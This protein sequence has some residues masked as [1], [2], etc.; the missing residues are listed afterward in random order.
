MRTAEYWRPNDVSEWH[1]SSRTATVYMSGTCEGTCSSTTATVCLHVMNMRRY[2]LATAVTVYMSE[3]CESM[4][5][6]TTA[7]YLITAAI[8]QFTIKCQ[9]HYQDKQLLF[10]RFKCEFQV[11]T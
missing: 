4:Y 2:V 6:P 3:T 5:S 10:S 1:K 11:R 8:G 7:S 9:T